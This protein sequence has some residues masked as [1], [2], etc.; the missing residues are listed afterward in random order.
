MLV[1]LILILTPVVRAQTGDWRAVEN[2][3]PGSRISV[4]TGH[5]T[6]CFF[7]GATHDELTCELP[8][9]RRGVL[10]G[11]GELT[12]SRQR[13]REVRLEHSEAA[14]AAVGAAIAGG[15]G[16]TVGA[17]V[18]GSG[19]LTRGGGALLLGGISAIIGGFVGRDFPIVHGQI[20]YKP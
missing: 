9:R 4:K 18:K 13:I 20:V 1:F 7:V 5:R 10:F 11:P 8:R 14:D 6:I 15:I 3:K 2:L 19:A 16:A 17:S 12:F